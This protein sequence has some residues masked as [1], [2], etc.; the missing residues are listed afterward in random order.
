[1]E[2]ETLA[3]MGQ[4]A[5]IIQR[6]RQVCWVGARSGFAPVYLGSYLMS[7]IGEPTRLLDQAGGVGLDA[8]GE[9]SPADALVAVSISPYTTQTVEAVTYA[10]ERGVQVIAVTD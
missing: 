6:S 5:D 8:L 1:C 7:L 4:A 3:A 2:P 9:L 10:A